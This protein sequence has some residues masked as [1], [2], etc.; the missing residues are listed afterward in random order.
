MSLFLVKQRER[1]ERER[2][3]EVGSERG[4]V[5]L[6]RLP[7]LITTRPD[8]LTPLTSQHSSSRGT[9]LIGILRR[10]PGHTTG[11]T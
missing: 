9:I 10:Q 11:H 8:R 2:E 7:P 4:P 1:G 6:F 3:R 5:R